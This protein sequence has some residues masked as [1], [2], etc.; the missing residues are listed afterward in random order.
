[1][2]K[3]RNTVHTLFFCTLVVLAALAVVAAWSDCFFFGEYSPPE[4]PMLP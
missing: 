2:A 3:T 1:M 4:I